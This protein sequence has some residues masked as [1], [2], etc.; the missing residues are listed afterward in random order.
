MAMVS[1]LPIFRN[2][3]EVI[4]L[5][6]DIVVEIE[7]IVNILTTYGA[8]PR[9]SQCDATVAT[10]AVLLPHWPALPSVARRG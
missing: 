5:N 4:D 3:L 6:L 1:F 9:L 2:R 8:F 10:G 7:T